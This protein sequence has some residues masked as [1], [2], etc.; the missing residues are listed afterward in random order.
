MQIKSKDLYPFLE[1]KYRLYANTDFID[2]DP[3]QVARKFTKKEDIEIAGFLAATIA[4][5]Q[6][7]TIIKNALRMVELMDHAPYDFITS[8][9]EIDLKRFDGFVHRTFSSEDAMYF[10]TALKHLYQNHGGLEGAFS[11]AN[12]AKDRIAKFHELFFETEHLPRTKKHV[13]NPTKGSS[14]KRLNMFLRWMI[15]PSKE[16]VDF[17]IW[18]KLS[19]AD[20]MLPLDVHTGNVGRKL[21]LLTR[22]QDDW[23]SVEE[24][25]AALRTFDPLDPVKYDF[26]LFGVGAFEK[27]VIGG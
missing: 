3:I 12:N 15:R 17:G 10:M 4:W 14:A 7:P 23:K 6:R 21:G 1:E 26:A 22:K 13:S 8:H 25:T 24:I 2:T 19:P 16:G 11:Q 9:E 27:G 18:T 20:L 5:G